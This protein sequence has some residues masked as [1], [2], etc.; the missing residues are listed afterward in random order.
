MT[1]I[2]GGYHVFSKI[3][4]KEA[5]KRVEVRWVSKGETKK[6][7]EREVEGK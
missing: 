4:E 2:N 7:K 5:E 3:R 6:E 1:K